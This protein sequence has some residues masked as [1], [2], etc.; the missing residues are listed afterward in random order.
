M[1]PALN[2]IFK[3]ILPLQK[4]IESCKFFVLFDK[5]EY[6]VMREEQYFRVYFS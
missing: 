2:K 1:F 4:Y 6:H 5:K 3:N